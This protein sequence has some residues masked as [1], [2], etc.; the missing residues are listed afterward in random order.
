VLEDA[1]RYFTAGSEYAAFA[2][3]CLG[4]LKSGMHADLTDLFRAA[5][6]A[7]VKAR[8]AA[9]IVAGRVAYDREVEPVTSFRR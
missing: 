8:I 7:V 9:T 4:I 2:E 1:L 5:P 3:D 6:P